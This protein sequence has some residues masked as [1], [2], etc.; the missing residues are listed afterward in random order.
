MKILIASD[1]HSRDKNLLE[2]IDKEEPID[3]FIH[4]GDLETQESV[5]RFRNATPAK[6]SVFMVRGNNDYMLKLDDSKEVKIG[7]YKAFITHGHIYGV[8][9]GVDMLKEEAKRRNCDIAM[10]G[11]THRP[12]LENVDGV[13]IL[14]PGSISYPRQDN[15]KPSYLIM[16]VDDKTGELNFEHKYL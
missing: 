6:C 10:F 16:T 13:I 4:L 12:F 11:H 3:I 14:N 2:V 9:M 5:N 8:S 7:K 1:T 15:R